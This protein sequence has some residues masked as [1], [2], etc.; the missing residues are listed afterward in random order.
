MFLSS[1]RFPINRFIIHLPGCKSISGRTYILK[2]LYFTEN[3]TFV[4]TVKLVV[5]RM[6][7]IILKGLKN[8]R[9]RDI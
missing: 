3:E 8:V 7:F 4:I 1:F 9:F 2:T 6:L 5:S